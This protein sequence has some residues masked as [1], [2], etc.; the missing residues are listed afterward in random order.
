LRSESNGQPRRG[1]DLNLS[2]QPLRHPRWRRGSSE[3][4]DRFF[5]GA[6]SKSNMMHHAH[7]QNFTIPRPTDPPPRLSSVALV[8]PPYPSI[9]QVPSAVVSRFCSYKYIPCRIHSTDVAIRSGSYTSIL[10]V[11]GRFCSYKYIPCRIH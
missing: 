8:H 3:G 6:C 9:L 5:G 11:V 2:R 10:D 4:L 7:P 1:K